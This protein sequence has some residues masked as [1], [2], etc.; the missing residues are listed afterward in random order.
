MCPDGFEDMIFDNFSDV[1]FHNRSRK[2]RLLA[3]ERLFK[4]SLDEVL[5][6]VTVAASVDLEPAVKVG[7]DFESRCWDWWWWSDGHGI[8]LE[9]EAA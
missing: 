1:F 9:I 6:L 5:E 4:D 2:L 8:K 7:G 3:V